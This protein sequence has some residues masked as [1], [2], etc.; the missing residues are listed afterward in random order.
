M[1]QQNLWRKGLSL[2]LA[3][4]MVL[5]LG[6]CSGGKDTPAPAPGPGESPAAS[7]S[8]DAAPAAP[9][10]PATPTEPVTIQYWH[11]NSGVN[12]EHILSVVKEFNE[13]NQY[14]ITVEATYA[15]KYPEILSK[16]STAI[17]SGDAPHIIMMSSTGFPMMA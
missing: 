9:D 5:A 14:G 13:T 7:P 8:S 12:E 16:T 2:A 15:G 17:A 10:Y 11:G 6:A 4:V 1:K 3:L